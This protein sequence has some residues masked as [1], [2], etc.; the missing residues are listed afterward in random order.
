MAKNDT[1]K[2]LWVAGY[3]SELPD[4]TKLI[5]GKTEAVIPKG[6]AEASDNWQIKGAS[7]KTS[8]KDGDE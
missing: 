8:T 3:E 2:A 1:V 7:N 5:P 6:E 4:K